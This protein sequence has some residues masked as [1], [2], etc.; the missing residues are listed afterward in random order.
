MMVL[1]P[2][3]LT[4]KAINEELARLGQKAEVVKGGGYFFFRGEDADEWIDRTVPITTISAWTPEQWI[5]EYRR[6][7]ALNEQMLKTGKPGGAARKHS[8]KSP[9]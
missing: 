1:I 2:M 5:E 4:L 8:G 9:H 6:L 7:K 3:R